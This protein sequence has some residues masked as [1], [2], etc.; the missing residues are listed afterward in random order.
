[1]GSRRTQIERGHTTISMQH[2]H[3]ISVPSFHHGRYRW[4]H[5][6][7]SIY[8]YNDDY[9][10]PG[11]SQEHFDIHLQRARRKWQLEPLQ[12]LRMQYSKS[13]DAVRFASN[14]QVDSSS[15]AG[16]ICRICSIVRLKLCSIAVQ[17]KS[18]LTIHFL[19]PIPLH[20][21]IL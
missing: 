17:G 18:S 2:M 9:S 14:R 8:F 6:S 5:L 10:V 19:N 15:M 12:H 21:L 16:Q 1:M 20:L 3:L 4:L 11:R 13:A 7:M